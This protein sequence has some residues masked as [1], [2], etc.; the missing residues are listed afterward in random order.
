MPFCES[1]ARLAVMFLLVVASLASSTPLAAQLDAPGYRVGFKG[2]TKLGCWTPLFLKLDN[3]PAPTRF[4]ITA[5][6]GDGIPVLNCGRLIA[7]PQPGMFQAWFK[8]GRTVGEIEI[9]VF[10]EEPEP[11]Y[12][13]K[14][15]LI[16]NSFVD[17]LNSTT[18]ICLTIESDDAVAN[19]LRSIQSQLFGGEC[20]IIA[21]NDSSGLPSTGNGFDSIKVI[22]LT[23]SDL[24][25]IQSISTRQW[26]ALEEWVAD[27][28]K[29][30][31]CA[32]KNCRQVFA[33]ESP[34]NRFL[35]GEFEGP[36]PVTKSSQF[37]NF[38]QSQ[39]GQLLKRDDDPLPCA[40]IENVT[41]VAELTISGDPIVVRN[42]YKFGQVVF[43]AADFDK[44]PIADWPGQKNYLMRLTSGQ[45][46]LNRTLSADSSSRS[47][48]KFGQN[49]ILGQLYFPLEKFSQVRFL[50]FTVIAVLIA[51]F[52]LC[53]GPGDFFFLRKLVGKMEW[54]WV[55]FTLIAAGFCGI[56]IAMSNAT[57]PSR[58]QINQ[59]E[60]IDF[61]TVSD[62]V[63][64]KVWTNIYSP[65]NAKCS[66]APPKR[67][68]LGV[69]T[70]K[71]VISWMGLPGGGLGGMR[72]QMSPSLFT[73]NYVCSF[74]SES[75]TSTLDLFPIRVSS[76]KA[77]FS[78]Y[79]S[80][81][82]LKMQSRLRLNRATNQLQGTITNPFEFP[83][84]D[85]R[86]VFENWAY[87]LDRPLEPGETVDVFLEMR[88]RTASSYFSRRAVT[89]DSKGG[90]IPWNPQ[91]DNINRIAEVMMFYD[92]A[93]G[94]RYTRLTHDYQ[95]N[96]DLTE[97]LYLQRA[98]LFCQ[99]Q[100]VCTELQI[101]TNAGEIDYDQCRT[102]MRIVLPVSYKKR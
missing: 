42:P 77:L 17:I 51:L 86:V 82:P 96:L 95:P 68:K 57:K 8:T 67:N 63:R 45:L 70:A 5:P 23:T 76:T 101:E 2:K 38:T 78:E 7:T 22:Y 102:F 58:V 1:L 10:A 84:K 90:D 56:A 21:L 36:L 83:L 89:N 79:Q 18:P 59:L 100:D 26:D 9:A 12:E 46:N 94:Q 98:I 19:D 31:F 62:S 69:D 47:V 43:S 16:E 13:K 52:V 81:Q 73:Q 11:I 66:V 14:I 37:E 6:D 87:I 53:V 44:G 54:T 39:R 75:Q 40:K 64:G 27:G 97:Q 32:G 61:D 99:P 25:L 50:N 49:D 91:E 3:D 35:P 41:G 30:I 20:E 60:V 88:E 93:G 71:T 72:S 34:L 48:V 85:C 24:S 29:L 33:N 80:N 15:Q 92:G 74:G 65:I 4:E 28:G 55:S